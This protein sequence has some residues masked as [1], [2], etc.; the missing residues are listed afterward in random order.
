MAFGR[1]LFNLIL[2]PIV[3]L[4]E[5]IY[6]CAVWVAM[7]KVT[8]LV[9]VSIALNI[10]LLPLY[11]RA[12]AIKEKNVIREKELKPGLDHIK[13]VFRGDERFMMIQAYY[14][15]CH[16]K[17]VNAL[18]NTIPLLL[19]VPFFI[20]A[21][22]V[23]SRVP[24]YQG[25]AFGPVMDLGAPDGL[26]AIGGITINVLPILMTVINLISGSIYNRGRSVSDHIQ[27]CALAIV[28][29]IL[30][31]DSP[32]CLVLY[33]TFNQCF[34]LVKNLVYPSKNRHK[35]IYC[36]L[37]AVSLLVLI[38]SIFSWISLGNP[39]YSIGIGIA[40]LCIFPILIH[41]VR[42]K[43]THR[44]ARENRTEL[45][46]LSAAVLVVLTGLLIPAGVIKSS[47]G[48]FLPDAMRY[49]SPFLRLVPSFTIAAGTFLVWGGIVYFLCRKD[50]RYILDILMEIISMAAIINH[51]FFGTK[52]G[53]LTVTLRYED[54]L[55]HST[56]D[57][58]RNLFIIIAIIC[59]ILYIWL[60]RRSFLLTVNVI[61]L[62]V[63]S[64]MTVF[65]ISGSGDQLFHL[66]KSIET[67]NREQLSIT[68]SSSHENVMV[69]MMDRAISCFVPYLLQENPKLAQQ[70]DGF[71]YFPNTVTYGSS[72]NT[73][74]PGLF[75]GYEYIPEE[76]NKRDQELMVDKHNE[77]LKVMPVLFSE[78]GYDVTV[79]DPP[80]A[81]YTSGAP[82]LSIYDDYPDINAC[83][84]A[85]GQ[86]RN[87]STLSV[88][89]SKLMEQIW[90]R[91][92][93]CYSLMKISPL[94]IQPVVY[95]GGNYFDPNRTPEQREQTAV[96]ISTAK[97]VDI[98]FIDNYSVLCALPD[99]TSIHDSEAG[100]FLMLTNNTTHEPIL[101]SEPEYEPAKVI[102]NTT[103]DLEHQQRFVYEGTKLK[104]ENNNQMA[105]Y[106]TN[107]AAM[108][109][110]GD[111]FEYMK[112]NEVYD[113]TKIII[114]SDHG[115]NLHCLDGTEYGSGPYEDGLQ[116]TSLL[117]V[118]DYY[119]HGFVT[120]EQ[121]MTNAD[122]PTLAVKDT[123][124]D[125]HN[126]FTGKIID[127]SD[128]NPA[129]THVFGTFD[130][131]ASQHSGT[132]FLPGNWFSVHDDVR[133][134]KNWTFLGH[135]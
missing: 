21:Y 8:S 40:I 90:D 15:I 29:L 62:I 128:K 52:N 56:I 42:K 116:L 121:F 135:Y 124:P 91:N 26:L 67:N 38:F 71:V 109:R 45:F 108:M 41:L 117:M 30:L 39:I 110:L 122:V 6:Q 120:N 66:K 125:A 31:Y 76:M 97:G 49:Q 57:I 95:Q 106:Q 20:A 100:S 48:Q 130:V 114:V 55:S 70:F 75:G 19:Q 107:M 22:R 50:R 5:A 4:F 118:K 73:G 59:I 82:D 33:W 111:W 35:I 17:P 88:D 132:T 12:D 14:R 69:I 81:G 46:I 64:G 13:R 102:D 11:H 3:L 32:S 134:G 105:H 104:M 18:K 1:F 84:A 72:T 98:D 103:Y 94:A 93:F 77:A 68:L 34:S 80:W 53:M 58:L 60:K 61:I 115:Y 133:A 7:D 16:Y 101:L 25:M 119:A 37:A 86:F 65:D 28:F 92:F 131:Q 112:E 87:E 27:T 36:I 2:E 51:M 74:A 9:L 83:L 10:L 43:K 96:G 129:D 126:P 24:D 113:N 47:P 44:R 79:V 78:A 63:V 23:L 85:Y 89:Y 54:Q 127:N 123:I 99:I